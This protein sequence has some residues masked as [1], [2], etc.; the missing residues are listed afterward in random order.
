MGNA[1]FPQLLNISY[2][3]LVLI[4]VIFAIAGFV[5]AEKIEKKFAG[6]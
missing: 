5:V 2:G 4:A 6:K 1:T 3:A